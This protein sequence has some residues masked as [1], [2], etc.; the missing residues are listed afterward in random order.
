MLCI[1]LWDGGINIYTLNYLLVK[2]ES[3]ADFKCHREI[4]AMGLSYL[5]L[6][7]G[8]SPNHAGSSSNSAWGLLKYFGGQ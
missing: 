5:S 7:L 4:V 8:I 1:R 2:P 3:V 6:V